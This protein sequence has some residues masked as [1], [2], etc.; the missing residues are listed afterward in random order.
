MNL[1]LQAPEGADV[2]VSP[3]LATPASE[4]AASSPEPE[5]SSPFDAVPASVRTAFQARGFTELSS[6][7][8]AVLDAEVEG[9]D[10]QISSQT[11]SGK[12]VALGFVLA[13]QLE[14]PP[15]PG[16]PEVL[17]IVPTREL[18]AQ[19]RMELSWLFADLP[20]ARVASVTG[21]TPVHRDRHLLSP[22]PRVLVGTPGRL[23]DHVR[24][25]VLKLDAV[26]A[27]ILDEADQMLDMGFREELEGILD[28]TPS[29][30]RT[31]LVSATFPEGIQR[32]A[33]CY[34]QEP[35]SI[36]G[37]RLGEANHDIEHIG[38]LVPPHQRYAAL[39]N[40]L[41]LADE[42]RTLVFVQQRSETG[43][44]AT[45]LERDGFAALPLSGELA[46]TQR[47]RTLAAFRTGKVKVL[48]ATDV[49]ARGLDVPDVST[50]IHTAPPFDD[51]VYT[52]RSGR[53]GRAGSH[54][55]SVLLTPPRKR[56]RVERILADAAV[57]L[58]WRPI[59]SAKEVR[60]K[61]EERARLA[62]EQ[63]LDAALGAEPEAKHLAQAEELLAERDAAPL[64]AVLLARLKPV[65]T[66]KPL[67]V[68]GAPPRDEREA[69]GRGKFDRG[70]GD[71]G[72]FDRGGFD[73]GNSHRGNFERDGFDRGNSDRGNGGRGNFDRD[74]DDRRGGFEPGPRR[75]TSQRPPSQNAENMVRFFVNWGV[76]QDANPNRLLAAIC[77]RGEVRGTDVG[78]ISIHPNASTFDVRAEVAERFE[79]LASRRDPRD[80]H[81]RIRKDRGPRVPSGSRR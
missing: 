26:K 73:R 6:V 57:E 38:H 11:G 40:L 16:G 9:R 33:E 78:S 4:P 3:D 76:N 79:R 64:V 25:G 17:V 35:F 48:I 10:L 23:L 18:A 80:P 34:Q 74:R 53:T 49:A 30:R 39:V 22:L 50:V 69:Y 32:L 58:K 19:V 61:V 54:G 55:R 37:T 41:L 15:A 72:N 8:R 36:E 68:S 75:Y 28:A 77:R 27:L 67:E 47:T 60:A 1:D 44:L 46:Q 66:A 24:S 31:H 65:E 21:G 2:A 81:T 43:E 56:R 70:N 71:R 13:P 20:A 63:E 52:H 62:L 14:Q 51:L 5:T 12:T 59:P 45:R 29:T 7:Q 42:R